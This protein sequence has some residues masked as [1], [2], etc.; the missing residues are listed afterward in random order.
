MCQVASTGQAFYELGLYF[1]MSFPHDAPVLHAKQAFFVE[2]ASN[3]YIFQWQ[4]LE[5]LRELPPY[6]SFLQTA[7]Q[8]LPSGTEHIVHIDLK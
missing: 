8:E 3:E 1:L 4:A 7:L 5:N 6:P 2:E